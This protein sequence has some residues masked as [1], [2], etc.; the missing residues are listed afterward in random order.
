[1]YIFHAEANEHFKS[2]QIHNKK[3][4]HLLMI[5]THT[6]QKDNKASQAKPCSP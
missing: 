5:K 1:M 6:N 4:T 3:N 2:F